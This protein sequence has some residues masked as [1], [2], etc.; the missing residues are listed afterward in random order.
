MKIPVLIS[1]LLAATAVTCCGTH[2][3]AYVFLTKDELKTLADGTYTG[4]VEKGLDRAEAVVTVK[5]G[6]ITAVGI[7]H[8]RAFDWREAV[9]RI[10][11]P[12]R[13][14]EKQSLD[15]DAVAGATGST[16]AAKMAVNEAL[17]QAVRN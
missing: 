7:P 14:L 6:R 9:V 13:I 15:I 3:D 16:H 4:R 5:D 11:V 10:V 2:D 12:K 1:L 8:V 17:K